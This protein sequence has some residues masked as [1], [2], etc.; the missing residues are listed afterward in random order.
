MIRAPRYRPMKSEPQECSI[1]G[2]LA[3][4]H[5]TVPWTGVRNYQ[6]RNF[7]RD[8]MQAGDDVLF[9]HSSGPKPGIAGLARLDSAARSDPTQFELQSP[10]YAPKATQEKPRWSLVDVQAVR[11]TRL[12]RL[13]E[14]REQP[15]LTEMKVLQKGS[16]LSITSVEAAHWAYI[17]RLLGE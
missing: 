2:A 4:T 8:D 10:Y 6:A 3:A 17:V 7:M 14:V 5:Q 11:K 12:L 1:D 13:G 9:Y 15:E 16:R